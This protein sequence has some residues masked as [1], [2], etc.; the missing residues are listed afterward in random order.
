MPVTVVPA[1]ALAGRAIVV[2]MS[3]STTTI[4]AV[5]LLLED[6]GSEVPTGAVTTATLAK[7]PL[8]PAATVTWKVMVTLPNGG[9]VAEPFKLVA[10]ATKLAVL[11][12]ALTWLAMAVRVPNPTG[13]LSEKLA[14]V[15]VLGPALLKTMV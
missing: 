4:V 3:V 13:K 9:I 2:L 6:T 12:P 1:T 14:P 15:A 11:A 10:V 5:K 8:I 7:L